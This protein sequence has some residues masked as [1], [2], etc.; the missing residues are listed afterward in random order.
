ML[1]HP[2][3][4]APLWLSSDAS[5]VGVG[6]V[7]EQLQQDT[8]RPL[9]FFSRRLLP[10]E[11]R[12]SAFDKELLG[13][14]LCV[15]HFQPVIEGRHCSLLTDHKPLAAAWSKQGDPWSAR[16]QRHLSA[17]AEHVVDVRHRS[18]VDN[19]VADCLS[20]GPLAA[21]TF[22]LDPAELARAQVDSSDVRAYRTALSGLHIEDVSLGKDGLSLVCDVSMGHPRPVVPKD[23]TRKVFDALHSL[24]HPGIRG[25]QALIG[26]HYV[27]HR[28]RSDI[29]AWCRQCVSCQSSK[30]QQHTR[31]PVHHIPV[32]ERPF[33][34]VHVDL[35]GPLP[36]SRGFTYLLTVIDRTTRWPE[37]FPLEGIT[38][39]ECARSFISGWVARY[40][41]PLEMTS[42]RGRQ[43]ISGLWSAMASSLGMSLHQTT[44]YHPQANG[45]VE[46]MHRSLK[47]A[48]RARLDSPDW[49]DHLPWVLLGLRSTP[50]E[51]SGCSPADMVFRHQPLLPGEF[52][53]PAPADVTSSTPFVAPFPHHHAVP[54]SFVHP[55][56]RDASHVFV[57]VDSHRTPLQRPY[58]GPFLVLSRDE[59]TFEVMVRNREQ[60][61]S[62]DRLKPA[63][64]STDDVVQPVRSP[65]QTRSGRT[66]R[67]PARYSEGGAYVASN[68]HLQQIKY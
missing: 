59:K 25:S 31:A 63:V 57:R 7:L 42:D 66:V 18:G 38:A 6:G 41:T 50:K 19:T 47:A 30:V 2:I 36:P 37:A 17:I 22:S 15:R 4:E 68:S 1:S 55:R 65:V 46:R 5:D 54:P 8:L 12:Y 51:D 35:V 60:R 9:G 3:P 10:Q 48:L 39:A 33:S 62:V 13:A 32:P 11:Q 49:M 64:L 14:Y 26:R 27:W 23:W 34:H 52:I 56:L 45:I 53:S 67:P 29:A 61:I 21:V 20:R 24:S 44:A 28:M 58:Q 40:G 43:F 16:Q